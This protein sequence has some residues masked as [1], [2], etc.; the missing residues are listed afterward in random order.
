MNLFIEKPNTVSMGKVI[1]GRFANTTKKIISRWSTKECS[2]KDN[3]IFVLI[4][5]EWHKQFECVTGDPGLRG[6][7]A[8]MNI[9]E[10][11]SE[12][13]IDYLN[14][15]NNE[16]GEDKTGVDRACYDEILNAYVIISRNNALQMSS[17]SA[18][19]ENYVRYMISWETIKKF[20]IKDLGLIAES[21]KK[22][23]SYNYVP[24]A[25]FSSTTSAGLQKD[26][27]NLIDKSVFSE[28][29]L[30]ENSI[31][32]FS[33]LPK[34]IASAN[35]I[36]VTKRAVM[37]YMGHS[38]LSEINVINTLQTFLANN[39]VITRPNTVNLYASG[40]TGVDNLGITRFVKDSVAAAQT[41]Q[42]V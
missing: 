25:V 28:G 7:D 35:T 6:R 10:L 8:N 19:W 11:T 29:V 36:W 3:K 21:E 23:F 22:N 13:V 16:L 40:Y 20:S 42:Q 15:L 12:E 17:M 31:D 37:E 30:V 14:N 18:I 34:E 27:K 32:V 38:K 39:K 4:D 5:F 41:T 9:V 33:Y 26:F 1:V 24:L 2:K